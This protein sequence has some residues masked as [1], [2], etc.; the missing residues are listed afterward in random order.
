MTNISEIS[1]PQSA[2]KKKTKDRGQRQA[3]ATDSENDNRCYD[4]YDDYAK[5][6]YMVDP[7][8]DTGDDDCQKMK[9][10]KEEPLPLKMQR[11]QYLAPPWEL[12][13][14]ECPTWAPIGGWKAPQTRACSLLDDLVYVPRDPPLR[15]EDQK[16]PP[17]VYHVPG[18]PHTL[19]EPRGETVDDRLVA[20]TRFRARRC[21]YH[22][23]KC[24]KCRQKPRPDRAERA[25]AKDDDE[26]IFELPRYALLGVIGRTIGKE[27]LDAE[28][29]NGNP[30]AQAVLARLSALATKEAAE[31]AAEAA[32]LVAQA[33]A[34]SDKTDLARTSS[35]PAVEKAEIDP[36]SEPDP[37]WVQEV[38]EAIDRDNGQ[39]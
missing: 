37:E 22:L 26:T 15:T 18:C 38:E 28:A 17:G 9:S 11:S 39:A 16:A 29:A 19:S 36:L 1:T 8:D 23:A 21:G 2:K 20:T 13:T 3:D 34:L 35:K 24:P 33:K 27:V 31:A 12:G 32:M 14:P 5:F 7:G 4:N 10:L 30:Q 25:E 6:E